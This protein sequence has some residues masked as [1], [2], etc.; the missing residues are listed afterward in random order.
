MHELGILR[1]IAKI[2]EQAAIRNKISAIRHI[3]LEIGAESGVVPCFLKKLYPV[4]TEAFPI[5]K[6]ADLII[7]TVTGRGLVIKEIEY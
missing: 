5:L 3:T 6:D 7:L 1:N 2:V 4:A